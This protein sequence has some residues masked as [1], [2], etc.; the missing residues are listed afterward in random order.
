MKRSEIDS[1]RPL[2]DAWRTRRAGRTE[3]IIRL[4]DLT[5]SSR[6]AARWSCA[7]CRISD[8]GP[9]RTGSTGLSGD[10]PIG[11]KGHGPVEVAEIRVVEDIVNLPAKLNFTSLTKFDVFENRDVIIEDRGLTQEVSGQVADKSGASWLAEAR[12]IN[13]VS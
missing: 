1:D 7:D 9:C 11:S 2:H 10:A 4:K 6:G 13:S 3:L 5:Q 8:H 12:G